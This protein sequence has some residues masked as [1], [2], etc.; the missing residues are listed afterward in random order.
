[1]ISYSKELTKKFCGYYHPE[2]KIKQRYANVVLGTPCIT[3]GRLYW[4]VEA[5]HVADGRCHFHFGVTSS[6]K[7]ADCDPIKDNTS[8]GVYFDCDNER[9]TIIMRHADQCLHKV[10]LNIASK[11]LIHRNG[12]LLDIDK[13]SLSV[14]DSKSKKMIY[15]FTNVDTTRVITPFFSVYDKMTL[16]LMCPD[17][18]QHALPI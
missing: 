15:S 9:T 7:P 10:V 13:R 4:E 14:I 18:I 6:P 12:L 8:W 16:R 2:S 3:S 17:E 1:M 5:A 11:H